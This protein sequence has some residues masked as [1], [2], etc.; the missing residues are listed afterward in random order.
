M[1]LPRPGTI[2]ELAALG[3]EEIDVA[4]GAALIARDVYPGL[5]VEAQLAAIDGLAAPLSGRLAGLRARDQAQAVSHHLF[6]TLGFRGNE[7]DYYDPRNSLLPDVLT[8]RLGIPIS[9]SLLYCEV[10]RRAG[11]SAHG[12]AFPGH[13]LVRVEPGSPATSPVIV[14][15]FN[16]GRILA[17]EEAEE[18]LQRAQGATAR[19][20]ERHLAPATARVFLARMLTN[21]RG[22]YES[23]GELARAFLVADRIATLLPKHGE[24]ARQRD[25]LAARVQQLTSVATKWGPS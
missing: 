24:A 2:D 21:L 13:F 11:V 9:L 10:A 17:D 18:L 23:R 4:R 12:V 6:E 20:E 7:E 5:D 3:D 14:D 8:R 1:G 15:P 16:A 19:L 22:I 25:E